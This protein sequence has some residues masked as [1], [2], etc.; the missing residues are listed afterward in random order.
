[1]SAFNS[2]RGVFRAAGAPPPGAPS[3]VRTA[4][5]GDSLTTHLLGYNWSPVFWWNG[6][7]GGKLQVLDAAAGGAAL[8]SLSPIQ[9]ASYDTAT[10]LSQTWGVAPTDSGT[11]ESTNGAGLLVIELPNTTRTSGQPVYLQ[12]QAGSGASTRTFGAVV[13]VD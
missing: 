2:G 8:A 1:M 10:Q 4:L 3:S 7:L 13:T 12:L 5:M 9:W 11:A 6:L